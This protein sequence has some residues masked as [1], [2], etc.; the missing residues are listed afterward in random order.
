MMM[1]A[2]FMA[3]TINGDSAIKINT[4]IVLSLVSRQCLPLLATFPI[5]IPII[6]LFI[7]GHLLKFR[8]VR[9]KQQPSFRNPPMTTEVIEVVRHHYPCDIYYLIMTIMIT[10]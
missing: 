10:I 7:L 1:T 9:M 2:P 8:Y 4:E 3:Q 6:P 5:H